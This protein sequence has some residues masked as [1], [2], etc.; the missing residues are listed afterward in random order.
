[1]KWDVEIPNLKSNSLF[2][3][4]LFFEQINWPDAT[5]KV[6]PAMMSFGK[7]GQEGKKPSFDYTRVQM[8]DLSGA[9]ADKV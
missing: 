6:F 1:M 5:A 4:F 3:I 8:L 2:F 7:G 9:T